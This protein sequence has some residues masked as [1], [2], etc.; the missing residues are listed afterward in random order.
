MLLLLPYPD[1]K[2]TRKKMEG[3]VERNVAV[4]AFMSPYAG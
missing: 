4:A 1:L 3:N 2:D